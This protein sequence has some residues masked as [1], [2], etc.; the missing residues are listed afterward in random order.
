MTQQLFLQ[1]MPALRTHPVL[2]LLAI[3]PVTVNPAETGAPGF[4]VQPAA[5]PQRRTEVAASSLTLFFGTVSGK[6][7]NRPSL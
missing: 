6:V 4:P 1:A 5:Y 3:Q 7:P 2:P